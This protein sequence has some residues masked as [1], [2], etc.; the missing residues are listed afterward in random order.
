MLKRITLII[1]FLYLPILSSGQTHKGFQ[2]FGPDHSLFSVDLKTGVLSQKL[3]KK[4]NI[5]IGKIKNW[6]ILKN[7]LPGDFA[8][9]SFYQGDSILIAI[10]GTGQIY[11]F[12]TSN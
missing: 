2:W 5:E 4:S 10:P 6:D 12:R 8:V 9:N 3:P 1:T 11:S 7:D